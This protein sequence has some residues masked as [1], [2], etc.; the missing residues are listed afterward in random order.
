M[1]LSPGEYGREHETSQRNVFAT[2]TVSCELSR[3]RLTVDELASL[4]RQGFVSCERRSSR[5]TLYKLR[6]RHAGRQVV[7]SLGSDPLVAGRVQACLAQHQN[8]A[9]LARELRRYG[10]EARRAIRTTKLRLKPIIEQGGFAFHG[11]ALRRRRLGPNFDL[12]PTAHLH[13]HASPRS[14]TQGN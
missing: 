6:F 13:A 12:P 5:R 14:R 11:L 1:N 4:A 10:R 2:G 8:R 9:H 3:L 7:R